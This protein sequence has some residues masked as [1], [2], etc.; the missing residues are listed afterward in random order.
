METIAN[1][2]EGKWLPAQSGETFQVINPAFGE[3]I[4]EAAKSSEIDVA[5]AVHA[6]RVAFD[7]GPWPR[8]RASER[9]RRL[10]KLA[11]LIRDN[12]EDI[13]QTESRNVGKPIRDSRDEVAAGANSFE[14]YAGAATKFFGETIP[15]TSNG[16]DFTVHEPCGV[17]AIIVPWNFPFPMAAWKT[18]PALAAGNTV[19]LKPASYA[20]MSAIHLARLALEADIPSGVFNLLQK[21]M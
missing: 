10:F 19:V 16:F 18:A 2:I 3:P 21:Y 12:L 17:C 5:T 6:S 11:E 7:S 15:V 9:A 14:Y 20:P 13:A 4:A 1:L 8:M